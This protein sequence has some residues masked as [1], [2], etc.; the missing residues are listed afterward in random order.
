LSKLFGKRGSGTS[1]VGSPV[2]PDVGETSGI[3]SNYAYFTENSNLIV[4]IS[5]GN[6]PYLMVHVNGFDILGMLDSGSNVTILGADSLKLINDLGLRLF[7]TS[8]RAKSVDGSDLPIMGHVYMPFRV[9]SRTAVIPTLIMPKLPRRLILGMD[10]WQEF[11]ISPTIAKTIEVVELGEISADESSHELTNDQRG[12]LNNVISKFPV[13]IN[14]ALGCTT[15]YEQIIDTGVLKPVRSRP[16]P[17][18]P[19]VQ[20]EV[21]AEIDRMLSLEVIEPAKSEWVSPLVAARKANGKIRVCLDSRKLNEITVKDRYPIPHIN[22]ILGRLESSKYLSSIDLS[23]AFWQIPLEKSSREKTAFIVMGRGMFQFKRMPFG[24]A[25]SPIAM[26]RLMDKVLGFDLEPRVFIYL[27]DIIVCSNSFEEHVQLLN[28]V[29]RRL[30]VAG[31]TI[32]VEKSK[33]CRKEVRYLG[34]ILNAEGLRPDPEKIAA[35]VNYPAPKKVRDVRRLLGMASFYRRFI[36]NFSEI[37]TPISDLLKKG[38]K[39]SWTEEAHRSFLELKSRLVE[40]PIL[41]SPDFGLPFSVEVDS[42]DF[43]V[44]A[45]LSQQVD[46]TDRVISYFSHKLTTTQRKYSATERECL[47]ALLAIEKFRPYI[48]G[49]HFRLVVDCSAITWLRNLKTEGSSRL[50]RWALKMQHLDM[51]I[52]HRKGRLHVVPDALSRCVEVASINTSNRWYNDLKS[53]VLSDPVKFSLFKVDDNRI[54]KYINVPG[55]LGDYAYDWKLVV[56]PECRLEILK[57]E[58]DQFGHLGHLKTLNRVRQKYYW[59]KMSQYIKRYV[60]NCRTCHAAKTPTTSSK[61]PMGRQKLASFPWQVVSTDYVG[62]L[63]RSKK[64]NKFL[65][66]VSDWFSKLVLLFPVRAAESK[67]LVRCMETQ[68]FLKY[69]VPE[70]LVSDNGAQ[71]TGKQFRELLGR[72]KVTH[73]LNAAYHPQSNPAERVNKVV[74]ASIRCYV[75][76]DQRDWDVA[77][78][79]IECSLNTVRHASTNFSP[80]FL[81]Y[82]REMVLDGS[83][84]KT[85]RALGVSDESESVDAR[86]RLFGELFDVVKQNLELS[87]QTQ[88]GYYNLR[89]RKKNLEFLPGSIVWKKNFQLSNAAAGYAAALGPKYV[90]CRVRRKIGAATYELENMKGKIIG[91]CHVQDLK[92]SLVGVSPEDD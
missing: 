8:V 49:V 31:L 42:S 7:E 19:Y 80:Y 92:P 14:G 90:E 44:G 85:R 27:D 71:F 86:E 73:W 4:N 81:N 78:P 23:D 34:Y 55:E 72:Y 52:E 84:F 38:R 67:S 74:K 25:N 75:D 70:I 40:A 11:K 36:S 60:N 61:V 18:S 57:I 35:I 9:E 26:A 1:E 69:G 10:F 89:A 22:R 43:G 56:A 77:V 32:N 48:D 68:V 59:P 20:K 21:N 30:T 47:G 41:C 33:F 76:S 54:F 62:P 65:L 46:G 5:N 6:R 2:V 66:V 37:T 53:R 83:D 12:T 16:Y 50:A 63:T 24:L 79:M 82:G 51:T 45:I 29:A 87:Y 91:K 64:G 39:F 13:S 88:A 58:H 28:E 15:I 3:S 17:L